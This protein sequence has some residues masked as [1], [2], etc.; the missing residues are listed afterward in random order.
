MKGT[1]IF[2]QQKVQEAYN[3][4]ILLFLHGLFSFSSSSAD[5]EVAPLRGGGTTGARVVS[6]PSVIGSSR[7]QSWSFRSFRSVPT[8]NRRFSELP[9]VL[10]TTFDDTDQGNLSR[11]ID[12]CLG[13]ALKAFLDSFLQPIFLYYNFSIFTNNVSPIW[14]S[15]RIYF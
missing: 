7:T 4:I 14:F 3:I 1:G 6:A 10:S 2:G 13:V 12:N 9:L 5:P 11:V 8:F 15:F